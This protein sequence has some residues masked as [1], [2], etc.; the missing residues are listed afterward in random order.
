VKQVREDFEM[1]ELGLPIADYESTGH[2]SQA[3]SSHKKR[4]VQ[5][6]SQ[7]KKQKRKRSASSKSAKSAKVASSRKD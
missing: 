5:S 2:L 7:G 6:E 1:P 3:P 4:R